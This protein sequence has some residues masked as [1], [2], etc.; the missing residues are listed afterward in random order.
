[1]TAIYADVHVVLKAEITI[2]LFI[3]IITIVFY[4]MNLVLKVR[5]SLYMVTAFNILILSATMTTVLAF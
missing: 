5:Q 2:W 3:Q 1:M 4:N